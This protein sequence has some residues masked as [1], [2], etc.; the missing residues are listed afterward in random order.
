MKNGKQLQPILPQTVGNDVRRVRNH[1]L[2]SSR[3]TARNVQFQAELLVTQ[4]RSESGSQLTLRCLRSALRCTREH[5]R[6]DESPGG[7]RRPSSWSFS[8]ARFPPALKPFR[9]FL[10]S[11]APTRL[12]LRDPSVDLLELPLLGIDERSY[13]LRRQKGRRPLRPLRQRIETLL[14]FSVDLY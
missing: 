7:T 6:G 5:G 1:Q 3:N 4:R 9:Y 11:D 12:K 10:V 14:G 8:L 13:S 2:A